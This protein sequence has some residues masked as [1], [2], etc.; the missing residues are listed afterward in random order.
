MTSPLSSALT[1]ER[2]IFEH[3]RFNTPVVPDSSETQIS[4]ASQMPRTCK[5]LFG[6]QQPEVKDLS[7]MPSLISMA[8]P[9]SNLQPLSFPQA[10]TAHTHKIYTIPGQTAYQRPEAGITSFS[11]PMLV[12]DVMTS[13]P[14]SPKGTSN[15]K[16][17]SKVS[18]KGLA[19][20][21]SR[22]RNRKPVDK[23]VNNE[24]VR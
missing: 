2:D 12:T 6:F 20:K 19:K 18:K 17:P 15:T 11:S 7:M 23:A 16:I 5:L 21:T 1:A 9:D 3:D 10:P 24:R 4:V 13:A 14:S 8:S 22:R